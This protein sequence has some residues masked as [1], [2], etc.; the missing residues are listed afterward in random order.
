M[1]LVVLALGLHIAARPPTRCTVSM[2]AKDTLEAAD[3]EESAALNEAAAAA[4]ALARSAET[5]AA[6]RAAAEERLAALR[7][8]LDAGGALAKAM[9]SAGSGS[10]PK[11]VAKA[12][13]KPKGSLAIVPEGVP[14]DAA[15]LGGIDLDDPAY[16]SES[17]RDGNAAAVCVR[18]SGPS[19]L[20]ADALA[21]TVAE[22]ETAR[23]DFPGPLPVISRDDVVDT[24]QLAKAK[25]DGAGAVVLNV[26]LN[27]AE[28]TKELFDQAR[29]SSAQFLRRNSFPRNFLTPQSSA[30]QA[31]G[32][33]LEA[34]VRVA[35]AAELT[36][37]VDMGAAIVCIGD[38]ALPTAVELLGQ[39]PDGVVSVCDVELPDVRGAWA[40][41]DEKFNAMICGK[42]LLE[43]CA[44]DRIP[45]AAVIKAMNSKGSVKFG[46]GMQKGR[47]EGAKEQLGTLSM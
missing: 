4:G 8:E 24:L 32:L 29:N 10:P 26:V 42:G 34:I 27:G 25:A 46:L 20:T 18:V 2:R 39:L 40:V 31:G 43:V 22:Q 16:I 33:G 3:A 7:T 35:D 45:P 44:R 38:C 9:E 21:A 23:G 5:L 1:N 12:L 36:A 30:P 41:R 28:K 47:M 15:S 11:K 13:K 14:I 6:T 17:S 19:M 37:A